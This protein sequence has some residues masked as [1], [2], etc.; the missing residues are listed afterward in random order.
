MPRKSN[1]G[2]FCWLVYIKLYRSNLIV[3]TSWWLVMDALDVWSLGMA[4]VCNVIFLAN[5]ID[6]VIRSS[7]I[8]IIR[9]V[10]EL[11]SGIWSTSN[12]LSQHHLL[13]IV[14]KYPISMIRSSNISAFLQGETLCQTAN[15]ADQHYYVTATSHIGDAFTRNVRMILKDIFGK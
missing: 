11:L 12:A 9:S 15:V 8:L 3:P 7:G 2:F 10:I 5:I 13:Y 14:E 4:T 1:I 6:G